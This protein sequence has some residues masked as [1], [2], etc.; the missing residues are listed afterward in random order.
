MEIK[1]S[2]RSSVVVLIVEANGNLVKMIKIIQ[3]SIISQLSPFYFL[4][5]AMSF[6]PSSMT[7]LKLSQ[8][9]FTCVPEA[10]LNLPQ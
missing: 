10:I 5:A 6:L 7:S 8:N 2:N 4:L 9:R 3:L 1:L